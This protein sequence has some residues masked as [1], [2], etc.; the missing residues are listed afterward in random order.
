MKVSWEYGVLFPRY[1]TIKNVPNHQPEGN[2]WTISL[3]LRWTGRLT[4]G[5]NMVYIHDKRGWNGGISPSDWDIS[6]TIWDMKGYN[7][8]ATNQHKDILNLKGHI[9]DM[10]GM[11]VYTYIYIHT[12]MQ[13]CKRAN[14]QACMHVYDYIHIIMKS[15]PRK[16]RN[17]DFII[18]LSWLHFCTWIL[19][20]SFW[21]LQIQ[22]V[23]FGARAY[24]TNIFLLIQSAR[25]LTGYNQATISINVIYRLVVST[26]L[27][28]IS[29]LG[30]LSPIYGKTKN[31]QNHQSVY[32]TFVPKRHFFPPKEKAFPWRKIN[33][34]RLGMNPH[35]TKPGIA[36]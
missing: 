27:K 28:N 21:S 9:W 8:T 26:P 16:C 33:R 24:D 2:E 30:W 35:L 1:G 11:H 13:T 12:C 17:T 22:Q 34:G 10:M 3:Q 20:G 31:V 32:V 4:L 14:M 25:Y 7:E 18:S 23:L 15:H 6:E 5:F 36:V 29:Q 19:H